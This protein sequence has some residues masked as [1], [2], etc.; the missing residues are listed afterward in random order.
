MVKF[1]KRVIKLQHGKLR[2]ISA[3]FLSTKVTAFKVT[4][5]MNDLRRS[6]KYALKELVCET[7]NCF[8]IRIKLK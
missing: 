5:I 2:K 7:S 3:I 4:L 1:L 8:I 6:F